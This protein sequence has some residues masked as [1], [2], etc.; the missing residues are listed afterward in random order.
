MASKKIGHDKTWMTGS[1][2]K[3]DNLQ[4]APPQA[5]HLLFPKRPGGYG[6]SGR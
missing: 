3:P 6:T 5:E 1:A 2:G 4:S